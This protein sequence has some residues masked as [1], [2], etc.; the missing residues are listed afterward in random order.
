MRRLKKLINTEVSPHKYILNNFQR[1]A[2]SYQWPS[3][4][5]AVVYRL[6]QVVMHHTSPFYSLG[7]RKHEYS[8]EI[9]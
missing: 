8:I 3:V 9:N 6:L 1:K 7:V 4:S 5:T 2:V